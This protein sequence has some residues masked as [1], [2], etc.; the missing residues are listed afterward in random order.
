MLVGKLVEEKTAG[1]AE[2]TPE[3]IAA[4]YQENID[5]FKVPEQVTASHILLA[6][7]DTDTDETK[8]EKKAK[9]EALKK[10]IAGGASFEELATANSDCPSSQRG[11]DLGSFGRGQMVP[12]FE[13][14]AFN[15]ETGTVSDIVETQFG[16]HLIKVTDHQPESVRSLDESS[17]QI[18]NYLSNQKKQEILVAYIKGL[19]EAADF[20]SPAKEVSGNR[21]VYFTHAGSKW[22]AAVNNRYKLIL[23]PIDDPWLFDLQKDPDELINFYNHPEY[24]QIAE[25]LQ[26][27][28]RKQIKQYNDPILKDLP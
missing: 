19:K 26:T 15:M 24:R 18:S 22:V 5:A 27:E 7:D 20:L 11:G 12:E 17:E 4:F 2:A 25:T 1:T 14:V 9:I 16:Y 21:I 3:E 8:A 10:Q 13:E 28:L 6:F 23:S